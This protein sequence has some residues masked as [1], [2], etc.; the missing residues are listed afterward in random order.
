MTLHVNN[1]LVSIGDYQQSRMERKTS[2]LDS[3]LECRSK[4][5]LNP[6][7]MAAEAEADHLKSVHSGKIMT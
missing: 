4:M 6:V 3:K 2:L 1:L 7:L 5:L